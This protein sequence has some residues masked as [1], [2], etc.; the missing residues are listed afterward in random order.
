[1]NTILT[2]FPPRTK[3]ELRD[4]TGVKEAEFQDKVI[5]VLS[6]LYTDCAVF[7]FYPNVRYDDAVWQPDLAMVDRKLQFWF[8]IEVE[9]A[10]HH[11]EKHV[12]PQVTAFNEGV[13]EGN[14]ATQMANGVGISEEQAH[15]VLSM[16]PRDV[17]VISNRPDE[18]WAKKLSTVGVQMVSISEYRNATTAQIVHKID[19]EL[20]P[21][22]RSLGFGRVRAD[23][24][25]ILTQENGFWR[26]GVF[27][28]FGPEGMGQWIC[29]ILEGRVWLMKSEGI[30]EFQNRAV[31]QFLL[32]NDGSL[33][34]RLP[35]LV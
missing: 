11:L 21:S 10:T 5:R 13:Y 34:V 4:P 31:V 16:I 2:D 30:I 33:A 3:Y 26:D 22:L 8:V 14:A 6:H 27:E 32:R 15:T 19:G 7:P 17:V 20:I 35:Y 9:I 12:L 18:R 23:D 28:I 24:S 29:S 1:M 25:V